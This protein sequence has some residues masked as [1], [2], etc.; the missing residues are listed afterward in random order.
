[1]L[2][3]LTS[4]TPETQTLAFNVLNM[5]VDND[6]RHQFKATY[7]LTYSNQIAYQLLNLGY[8]IT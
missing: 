1:M 7:F 8:V 4:V 5:F 3:N 2:S 6:F